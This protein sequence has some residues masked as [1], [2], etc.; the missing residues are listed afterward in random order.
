MKKKD[1][2]NCYIDRRGKRLPKSAIVKNSKEIIDWLSKTNKVSRL[3]NDKPNTLDLNKE[4][5]LIGISCSWVGNIYAYV[6]S[7]SDED[8]TRYS[9]TTT[10]KIFDEDYNSLK[11]YLSWVG[12]LGSWFTKI[13]SE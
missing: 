8:C 6:H 4:W 11:K 12:G 9:N 5:L 3:F 1:F 7:I 10:I 13:K 2:Y